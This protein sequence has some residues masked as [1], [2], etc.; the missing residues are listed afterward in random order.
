MTLQRSHMFLG[1][2]ALYVVV[3]IAS[4]WWVSHSIT[5]AGLT[6]QEYV[7]VIADELAQEQTYNELQ[8]LVGDTEVERN[9]L[10]DHVLTKSET[11][12]FLADIE[13]LGKR[14]GVELVTNS[15]EEKQGAGDFDYLQINFSVAGDQQLVEEMITVLETLPYHSNLQSLQLTNSNNDGTAQLGVTL[16]VSLQRS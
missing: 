3:A 6:L 9:Q 4:V 16:L 7:Q 8:K 10:A 2:A 13:E 14:R 11:I 5:K 1:I 15:L 12:S